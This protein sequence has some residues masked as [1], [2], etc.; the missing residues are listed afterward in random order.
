MAEVLI[1]LCGFIFGIGVGGKVTLKYLKYKN[2]IA[3]GQK[4]EQYKTQNGL[5]E[6]VKRK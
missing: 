5:Y 2:K 4:Y 3:E 6:G 1:F